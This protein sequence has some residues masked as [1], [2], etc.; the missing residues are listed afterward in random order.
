MIQRLVAGEV[1][2]KHHIKFTDAEG[3]IRHEEAHTREGFDGPFTL[4]YHLHEPHRHTEWGVSDYGF[5]PPV[6]EGLDTVM[7]LRRRHFKSFELPRRGGSPLN[8]R[9]ALQ[10][11]KDVVFSSV[12]PTESDPVYFSNADGDDLYYIHKGSGILRTPLGDLRFG[13]R[14]YVCVPRSIKHRFV[15][16]EGVEQD[17]ICFEIRN[18]IR[19]PKQWLTHNGQI[20][21]DAPFCHRDFIAPTFT[22]PNDEGIRTFVVK[23]QDRFSQFTLAHS[24]LDVVGWDGSVYPWTFNILK[25]QARAGLVHLPP[26]WHG[27]FAFGGGIICSFVPRMV[28]FHEQA[29]PCPYPHEAVHCDEILF[30]AEGNFISRKGIGS[31]SI[32]YH[33]RGVMHGPHPGAYEGSIGHRSTNELAV[34]MDTFVPLEVCKTAIAVED[35]DYHGSWRP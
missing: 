27:T 10:F 31:G 17:W 14:D 21:M 15:L 34:M 22:G 35:N 9:V 23:Q 1:P 12:K 3:R 29:I 18:T 6:A 30:Y 19:L 4:M 11:N 8:S 28:D 7:P 25:F 5:A 26:D 32:S 33:P 16:D 20:R 24:P 2:A 13:H